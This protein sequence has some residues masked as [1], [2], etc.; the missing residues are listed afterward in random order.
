MGLGSPWRSTRH[1]FS[2]PSLERSRL[3]FSKLHWHMLLCVGAGLAWVN[4]LSQDPA[5]EP[6]IFGGWAPL[7]A[8]LLQRA[9]KTILWPHE[10]KYA[11][12]LISEGLG[13]C[14]R[15]RSAPDIMLHRVWQCSCNLVTSLARSSLRSDKTLIMG[16]D[17]C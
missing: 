6:N 16:L 2:I 9:A 8:P 13:V 5:T 11:C 4:V 17:W 3:Q 10:R 7:E 1:C 12:G 14:P 15:C